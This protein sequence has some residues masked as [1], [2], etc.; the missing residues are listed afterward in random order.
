MRPMTLPP[1]LAFAALAL[2]VAACGGSDEPPDTPAARGAELA[3]VHGC[4][5]CH[6]AEG[7]GGFGP[8]WKGL[9]GSQVELTDGRTVVADDEYLRRS[10]TDPQADLRAGYAV[11]MPEVQLSDQ[12][13]DDLVAHIE[14]L[15]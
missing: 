15:R 2:V 5:S 3:R 10:I 1:P 8:P 6:G 12:Q 7:Q 11:R 4:A 14:S 9:P 13:V